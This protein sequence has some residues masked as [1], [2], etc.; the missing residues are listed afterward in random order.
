LSPVRRPLVVV[1]VVEVAAQ[2]LA[3]VQL[4]RALNAPAAVTVIRAFAAFATPA[5]RSIKA[6]AMIVTAWSASAAIMASALKLVAATDVKPTPT[7]RAK[8][9]CAMRVPAS[10]VLTARVRAMQIAPQGLV[11]FCRAKMEQNFAALYASKVSN[12]RITKPACK[13]PFAHPINVKAQ[14]SPVTLMEPA[15]ASA[16]ISVKAQSA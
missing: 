8:V 11:V 14:V 13:L 5:K 3:P 12:A 6:A 1:V 10:R 7:A 15:T 4:M 16:L 9:K 2:M